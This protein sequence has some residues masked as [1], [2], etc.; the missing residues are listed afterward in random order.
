M[1]RRPDFDTHVR[2]LIF[3]VRE[4]AADVDLDT[5]ASRNRWIR[6]LEKLFDM[7]YSNAMPEKREGETLK[8]VSSKEQQMWTHVA[9]HLG[10]AMGNLSKGYDKTKFD[11]DLEELERAVNDIDKLQAQENKKDD[12]AKA[13]SASAK[14]SPDK[15]N[16]SR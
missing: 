9:A 15:I 6:K 3:R 10:L 5:Q 2:A 4:E 7:A 8:S 12:P 13:K 16:D 1:R 11:E 14:C